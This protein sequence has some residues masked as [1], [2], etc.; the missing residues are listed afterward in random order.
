METMLAALRS[1]PPSMTD[2]A[3]VILPKLRTLELSLEFNGTFN[4]VPSTTNVLDQQKEE[5]LQFF[6]S[7]SFRQNLSDMLI[8]RRERSA[9]ITSVRLASRYLDTLALA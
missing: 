8:S 9:P 4:A 2:S 7:D 5:A 6:E 3:A 1:R